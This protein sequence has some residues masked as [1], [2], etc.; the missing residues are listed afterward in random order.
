M[1]PAAGTDPLNPDTD[2][3]GVNDGDD[4]DP[5]DPNS[6]SDGDGVSDS[7]ETALGE[8]PLMANCADLRNHGQYVSCVA[9]MLNGLVDLGLITEDEKDA[10][11]SAAGGSDVA[12]PEKP[13]K[14]KKNK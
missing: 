14:P 13:E 8:D 2:G 10:R 7:D 4:I 6:D 11:Q 3:D 1:V 12:K 9:H 5:L